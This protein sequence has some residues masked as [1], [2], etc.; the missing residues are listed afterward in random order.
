MNF[1]VILLRYYKRWCLAWSTALYMDA[2]TP[3]L[4]ILNICQHFYSLLMME[5]DLENLQYLIKIL[6]DL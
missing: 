6:S 5:T 2:A 1:K 4:N 3:E